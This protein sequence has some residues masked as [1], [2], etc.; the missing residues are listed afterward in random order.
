ME[1]KLN[2]LTKNSGILRRLTIHEMQALPFTF[3]GFVLSIA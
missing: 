3:P 2:N 1:L